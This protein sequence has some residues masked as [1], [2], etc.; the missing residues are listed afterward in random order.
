MKRAGTPATGLYVG[1]GFFR[2]RGA[3]GGAT[4][5]RKSDRT[6]ARLLVGTSKPLGVSIFS[7]GFLRPIR[8]DGDGVALLVFGVR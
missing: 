8:L 4:T 5:F 3:F 6:A 2:L 1:F 7:Y